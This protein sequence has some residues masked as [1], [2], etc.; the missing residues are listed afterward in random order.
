VWIYVARHRLETSNAL[1]ELIPTEDKVNG[2][3]KIRQ[4]QSNVFEYLS[5]ATASEQTEERPS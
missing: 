4:W 5:Q 2:I 1:N 3:V